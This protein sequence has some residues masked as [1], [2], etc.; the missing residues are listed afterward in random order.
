ME[1]NE[2]LI[3]WIKSFENKLTINGRRVSKRGFEKVK[4]EFFT[5]ASFTTGVAAHKTGPFGVGVALGLSMKF[6]K[7]DGI[8]YRPKDGNWYAAKNHRGQP[9][10]L[11]FVVD[12]IKSTRL[13]DQFNYF[14]Q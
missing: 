6:K 3:K 5:S 13:Y 11:Q 2:I 8:F 9:V 4:G 10:K 1:N 14:E 12:P 7:H